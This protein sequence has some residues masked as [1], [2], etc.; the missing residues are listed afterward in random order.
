[1]AH[2]VLREHEYL[3]IG[4]SQK[5]GSFIT[6]KQ[7]NTLRKIEHNLPKATLSWGYKR[8]KFSQYCGVINLGS[9]F[10]EILPKIFSS[11]SSAD[12]DRQ[13]L[14][15]MLYTAQNLSAKSHASADISLQK[16]HL[17]DI[18][19]K[20]FCT[21]LFEQ[22][23]QGIIKVYITREE[24]LSVL[25]GRM[26]MPQHLRSNIAHQEKVY[27]AYDE[28]QEDNEYNW[29]IKATL[30]LLFKIAKN[31]RIKQQIAELLSIF[32]NVTDVLVTVQTVESLKIDRAVSRYAS[33][34]NMCG[35]F[36][37]GHSPDITA[38]NES[39][40]SLLFDMN[41][42]FESFI[43]HVL[44]KTVRPF[45]LR[46]REQGPQKYIAEELSSSKNVFL[47]KPDITLLNESGSPVVILD[48]KWKILDSND[49]KRGV[50]QSDIYQ[51]LAYAQQYKCN[52]VVLIYPF[53]SDAG[54][55]STVFQT[56]EGDVNV[57]VWNIDLSDLSSRNKR[58]IDEQ[59]KLKLMSVLESSS[60]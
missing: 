58:K 59:L 11:D 33:I 50:S 8:V 35:W 39:S 27:C 30:N 14:I 12:A 22:I 42:L 57:H 5:A 32:S 9:T 44:K 45:N 10:I 41:K 29:V 2:I 37:K 49:N 60:L 48:T 56:K 21:L 55:I 47:M 19:I 24:N 34:F 4:N 25:R 28:L 43:A 3:T 54:D 53:T 6:E 46:L 31:C 52:T 17:L 36:I 23:H 20:Q 16:H 18:F 38:G 15:K 13:I 7:A 26:L 51:L 1:M 40:L